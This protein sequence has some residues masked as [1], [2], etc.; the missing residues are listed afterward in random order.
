MRGEE[1]AERSGNYTTV[2]VTAYSAGKGCLGKPWYSVDSSTAIQ[3]PSCRAL[4][5]KASSRTLASGHRSG[6]GPLPHSH[7]FYMLGLQKGKE[8]K[9]V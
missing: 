3:S 4:H 2:S 7:L 8:V 5:T 6:L 1:R 9:N